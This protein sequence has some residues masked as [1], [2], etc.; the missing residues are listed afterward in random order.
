MGPCREVK[1]HGTSQ[2]VVYMCAICDGIVGGELCKTNLIPG[3]GP[4]ARG[5]TGGKERH[6]WCVPLVPS[7]CTDTDMIMLMLV[8]QRARLGLHLHQCSPNICPSVQL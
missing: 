1:S 4:P 6:V 5:Q 3:E 8:A 7:Y 2:L